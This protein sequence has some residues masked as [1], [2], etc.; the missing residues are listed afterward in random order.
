MI[1]IYV[2]KLFLFQYASYN[3]HIQLEFLNNDH[4][5]H[6]FLFLKLPIH[7]VAQSLLN[8]L[9]QHLNSQL[10]LILLMLQCLVFLYQ[11]LYDL[12]SCRY[13]LIYKLAMLNL[14]MNGCNFKIFHSSFLRTWFNKSDISF[15]SPFKRVMTFL[16]SMRVGPNKP[17]LPI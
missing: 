8:H 16:Y 12:E 15:E 4:M 6:L 5:F 14:I 7:L 11:L 10:L 1:Y 17:M 9:L 3:Y 2:Q 13:L